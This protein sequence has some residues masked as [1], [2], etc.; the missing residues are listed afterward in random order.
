MDKLEDV[1]RAKRIFDRELAA[2]A[3]VKDL[4]TYEWIKH[5][6]PLFGDDAIYIKFMVSRMPMLHFSSGDL[7][8]PEEKLVEMAR[9]QIQAVL[10]LL[11][12]IEEWNREME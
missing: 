10:D 6:E 9:V 12:R 1:E 4:K 11:K 8:E 3:R 2:D 5:M 7:E